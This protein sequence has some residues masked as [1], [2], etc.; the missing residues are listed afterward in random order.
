VGGF[1]AA[2]I[3]KISPALDPLF[4]LNGCPIMSVTCTAAVIPPIAPPVSPTAILIE[5]FTAAA[6]ETPFLGVGLST[7]VRQEIANVIRPSL[8]TL[9]PL[10][11]SFIPDT[12]DPEELLP[13]ISQR[14]N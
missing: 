4:T 11:L 7:T 9:I 14:D 3:S 13:N 8:I 10:T 6:A 12:Q 5:E 2:I 1:E